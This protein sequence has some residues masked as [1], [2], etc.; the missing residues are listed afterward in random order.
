M[1][2]QLGF[3]YSAN[4]AS[5]HPFATILHTSASESA[6]PRL[7]EKLLKANCTN[8]TRSFW[9]NED[10]EHLTK[11]IPSQ[12]RDDDAGEPTAGPSL[13]PALTSEHSLIY[14]SADSEYELET[15]K[16][17]EVYIIGGIVDRNR[18]KVCPGRYND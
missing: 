12:Q 17:D 3:L 10:V 16:E 14:L 8:W 4:R 7:W 1:A 15:I 18:Y 5:P 6:S 9:W 13:P 2:S 11:L